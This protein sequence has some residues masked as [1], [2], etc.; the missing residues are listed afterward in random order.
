MNEELDLGVQNW[1]T[2]MSPVF[3]T[4]AICQFYVK[5]KVKMT[6]TVTERECMNEYMNEF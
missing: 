6:V 5:G 2:E 1:S 4:Q 3:I